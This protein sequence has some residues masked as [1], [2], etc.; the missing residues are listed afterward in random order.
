YTRDPAGDRWGELAP[1]AQPGAPELAV[2]RAAADPEPARGL[3]R[4]AVCLRE[5][6]LER[7][8][9]VP[10]ERGRDL[11]GSGDTDRRGAP[12]PRQVG[13]AQARPGG[14]RERRLDRVLE[15]AHVAGPVV[16]A[17][18][19]ERVVLD[20]LDRPLATRVLRD[21]VL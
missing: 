12:L 4:V 7:G 8:A 17:Q 19:L 2:A 1:R 16:R 3:S 13:R 18:E 10:G 21:E 6:A 9:V 14:D 15:L 11:H 20:A 5:R